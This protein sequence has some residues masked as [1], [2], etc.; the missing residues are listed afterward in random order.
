VTGSWRAGRVLLASSL[1]LVLAGLWA[2][3]AA[4]DSVRDRQWHLAALDL[5]RAHRITEGAGVTVAVIDTGVAAKHRDL[6]SAV[7]RGGSVYPDSTGD[8]RED[9]DGHGTEMAG[10][11]A[12]RGHGRGGGS[13]VLGVAPAAK[14]LP[15][16]APINTFATADSIV[17]AISYAVDHDADVINMSFST[18][19]DDRL[20][21]AIRA[22]SAAGIVVVAAAGNTGDVDTG[23]YPGKFPEV[24]TVGA[25]DRRGAVADYSVRGPQLEIAA[26]GTEI[27]T[28][29]IKSSGYCLCS[30][31]SEAAAVVS[32]AAALVRARYPDLSAAE[33]I[34]RLT[35]TAV[36]AGPKGRDDAYGYGRLDLV[37][38]LTAKVPPLP[39]GKASASARVRAAPPV[40]ARSMPRS[41]TAPLVV[42]GAAAL[43]VLL[44]G[45][46]AVWMLMRRRRPR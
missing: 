7:L 11:I 40:D 4:A 16:E 9:V 43:V 23:D 24:L 13:G 10:I 26:P 32:G 37:R 1:S 31:T 46:L 17:D 28:T 38:A 18:A 20:R 30:G 34:H 45:G 14:I 8:G 6:A 15:I 12:G 25:V 27:V 42:T 29:G 41:R 3:P 33:V 22:A 39:A 44:V 36:D 2:T 21:E 5:P 19:N 35:A